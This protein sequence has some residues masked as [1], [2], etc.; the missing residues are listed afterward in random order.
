MG[1]SY[2]TIFFS[3]EKNGNGLATCANGKDP[4]CGTGDLLL[5]CARHFPI[6]ADLRATLEHWSQKIKGAD[7]YSPFVRAT[8]VRLALLAIE[9][10]V[11][12]QKDLFAVEHL[13]P[14]IQV[15]A[16]LASEELIPGG[17]CIVINPPYTLVQ[18]PKTCTWTSG[19]VTQAALFLEKCVKNALPETKIV[20]ILPDVLRTG[21]R[22]VRWREC[23]E[24]YAKIEEVKLVGCFDAST[25][26][27]I[28]ICKLLVSHNLSKRGVDWWISNPILDK[29]TRRVDDYFE[30][31]VGQ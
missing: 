28:F 31:R 24:K 16:T 15:C 5:A 26:V 25:D 8:K 18:A 11:K 29:P 9:R 4:T 22:Y 21:S 14:R 19:L 13:F 3:T 23:I 27:D 10:G 12:P 17:T 30:V 6:L 7:L 20:A 1:Y 2:Y